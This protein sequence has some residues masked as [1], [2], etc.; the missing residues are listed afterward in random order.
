MLDVSWDR[1]K[2]MRPPAITT[3]LVP[4]YLI[5]AFA[6][7][8][9]TLQLTPDAIFKLDL[10]RLSFYPLVFAN[11]LHLVLGVAC[12][13]PFCAAFEVRN[14]T[15]RTGVVLNVA[16]VMPGLVDNLVAK[17]SGGRVAS[18]NFCGTTSWIA[19]FAAFLSVSCW[20]LPVVPIR[21]TIVTVPGWV[22]PLVGY[23]V[24]I[25]VVPQFFVIHG[26]ALALG[27]GLGLL[28][29]DFLVSGTT[30]PVAWIESKIEVGIEYLKYIVHFVKEVEARE[31]RKASHVFR[32]RTME[33]EPEIPMP[34]AGLTDPVA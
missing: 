30:T 5:M 33:A 2:E 1:I 15:V 24:S 11:W 27:Y 6:V 25:L 20:T 28:Y 21:R 29:L 14:G 31:L 26:L 9:E 13:T 17:L 19:A 23:C 32:R 8:H 18:A 16:A 34:A 7:R 10:N 22:V 4:F 12:F 3:G